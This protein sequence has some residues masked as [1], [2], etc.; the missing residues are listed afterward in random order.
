[1][2]I[3]DLTDPASWDELKGPFDLILHFAAIN[4]GR[5]FYERPYEV[6]QTMDLN[7][8]IVEVACPAR[9]QWANHL[10][11]VIWSLPGCR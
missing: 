3:L 10:D 6:I 7:D 2:H 8:G 5:H 9:R 4:G 1:M 11:L